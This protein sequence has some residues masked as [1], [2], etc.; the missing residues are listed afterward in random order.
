VCGGGWHWMM[1]MVDD[2]G[3][4]G[5]RARSMKLGESDNMTEV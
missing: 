5:E 1:M 4:A 3:G 2:G